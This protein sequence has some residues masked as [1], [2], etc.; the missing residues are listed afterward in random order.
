MTFTL[1]LNDSTETLD[2]ESLDEL[3]FLAERFGFR[4]L[5]VDFQTMTVRLAN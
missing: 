4:A 3:A 2:V 5:T 1:I